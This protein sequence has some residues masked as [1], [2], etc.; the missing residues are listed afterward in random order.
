MNPSHLTSWQWNWSFG[1]MWKMIKI[2]I[3]G[4]LICFNTQ[5]TSKQKLRLKSIVSMCE[6]LFFLFLRVCPS[7]SLASLFSFF[8]ISCDMLSVTDNCNWMLLDPYNVHPLVS[9]L[10]T[11]QSLKTEPASECSLVQCFVKTMTVISKRQYRNKERTFPEW[12]EAD[13]NPT[14]K[15]VDRLQHS[16][17]RGK[18]GIERPA[19]ATITVG[20]A[21]EPS[22]SPP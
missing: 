13:W 8:L 12:K 17:G 5:C 3:A 22:S 14:Y 4:T 19:P 9:I 1:L 20:I 15:E 2:W 18:E 11:L 7:K 16:H 21:P 10:L 6:A